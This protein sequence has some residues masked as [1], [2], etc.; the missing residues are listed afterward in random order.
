MRYALLEQYYKSDE[1]FEELQKRVE[2][3]MRCE[4]DEGFRLRKMT[5]VYAVDCIAFIE[6]WGWVKI[7]E[8]DSAVKPFFLMAYQK[9]IILKLQN[10]E[11]DGE[12]HE[13]LIDKLREM[14]LTWLLV[15]YMIWRWMFTSGWSAFVLSRTETEVDDGSNNPD[16]SVFGK[17]RWGLAKIPMWMKPEGFRAKGKKGT[18]TDMALRILNPQM[19]TSINGSTTNANAGRSRRYSFTFVDEAFFVENFGAVYTALQSV[20]RIKVFVSTARAGFQYKNLMER[21]KRVG[22]YVTLDWTMNRF[23]DQIWYDQQ[24]S[25]AE[26]DEGILKELEV[27][28]V[29]NPKAQYYPEISKSLVKP[30]EYNPSLPLY[31]SLDFGN[32]DKTVLV[33]VQYDGRNIYV[34][35]AYANKQKPLEWYM[36]FLNWTLFVAQHGGAI[37]SMEM[38]PDRYND[39]Q[40]GFFRKISQWRKPKAFFGEVAHFQR[41]MPTNSSV[42]TELAKYGPPGNKIRLICNTKAQKYEPRRFAT[43]AVL[44][45]TIFNANDPYVMELFDALQNS[46]Y[47]QSVKSTSEDAAKKPVHDLSI[48]DFRSAFENFA[49]NFTRILRV[50]Q[51]D[52]NTKVDVID[53]SY[54]KLVNYLRI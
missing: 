36:P 20:S 37:P 54:K 14:G 21:C 15:W 43:V 11:G 7:P 45:N 46:R 5:D 32:Q 16:N 3:A 44:P 17:I 33:Y 13:I 50:A 34:P 30:I 27:S 23:K 12:E 41:V 31:I 18:S 35:A 49:V 24:K 19:G 6:Q 52:K 2:E 25:K 4:Q 51:H 42:A 1:Y 38:N 53:S 39:F 48:A 47:S 26:V 22:D 28:Y 10:A 29:V 40:M 9:E 8:Y